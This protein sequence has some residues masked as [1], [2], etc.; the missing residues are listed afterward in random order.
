M[1]GRPVAL[2]TGAGRGIGRGIALALAA[3][4]FDICG[5][6]RTW[7]PENTEKGLF[8]VKKLAEETGATFL[9][10]QADI[11]E[12]HD[13]GRVIGE[14]LRTFERINVLVN[15]AG[16]APL[17]RKDILETDPE[18]FDRALTI[19]T[20]GPFFFTQQVARHMISAKRLNPDEF[21]TVIFISSISAEVSSPSRAEYCLSKAALSLS[22]MIYADRLSE[23]GIAVYDVRPGIISTDMTAPVK[24]KYDRMIEN[25]L[26]PLG[27]WGQP[28]D[29]GTAVAAL[30]KGAFRYA[31]GISIEL[32]GGMNIR[33][34]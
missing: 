18:S 11:A 23:Y 31:T 19:N 34:L 33:H 14:T 29:I 3:E 25:G 15:N 10:L 9:P 6:G 27:S 7:E 24:E 30:A 20:R 22:S 16:V 13:H 4:G 12:I 21:Y 8:E 26:I 32:S 1:N 28:E 2:V 5:L 17:E